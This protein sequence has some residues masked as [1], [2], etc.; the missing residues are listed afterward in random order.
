MSAFDDFTDDE[1][2]PSTS[3]SRMAT[4]REL[5]TRNPAIEYRQQLETLRDER[6]EEARETRLYTKRVDSDIRELQAEA[7]RLKTESV[8]LRAKFGSILDRVERGFSELHD[9]C[10]RIGTQVEVQRTEFDKHRA[11]WRTSRA[12]RGAGNLF[13]VGGFATVVVVT[14]GS[15]IVAYVN[16][17]LK[18]QATVRP[19]STDGVGELETKVDKSVQAVQDLVDAQRRLIKLQELSDAQRSSPQRPMTRD[20]DVVTA[21]PSTPR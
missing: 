7:V 6:A 15:V 10:E 8:E 11:E 16:A 21:A 2:V 1:L 9:Q 3:R 12:K 20:P 14:I 19:A 18:T 4:E 17:P 5:A 13:A